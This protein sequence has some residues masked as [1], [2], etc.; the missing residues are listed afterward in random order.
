MDVNGEGKRI[1]G[2]GMKN[3]LPQEV[4]EARD[5][6]KDGVKA[7]EKEVLNAPDEEVTWGLTVRKRVEIEDEEVAEVKTEVVIESANTHAP[8]EEEKPKTADEEALAALLGQDTKKKAPDMVIES[9]TTNKRPEPISEEDAYRRAI[10]AAPE[11]ST[12]EDYDRVPVEEF[13]AALL[14]GM[15]WNG[16]KTGIVKD[17]KR[18]QNLLGLGAKQLKDAEEL[19]AWVQKSDTKRLKPGTGGSGNGGGRNDGRVRISDYRREEEE[20]RKKREERGGGS[21]RRDRSRERSDRGHSGRDRGYDR[22]R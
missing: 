18:R 17:V 6:A 11:V 8:V 16:E 5:R 12:L 20:R 10:A 4:L 14:R 2:A 19:G 15:G 7:V 9:L 13:G 1:R 21:Y 3:L 22:R